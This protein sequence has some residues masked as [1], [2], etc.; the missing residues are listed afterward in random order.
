MLR[1]ANPK[2]SLQAVTKAG[3]IKIVTQQTTYTVEREL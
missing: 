3:I 1:I 2:F